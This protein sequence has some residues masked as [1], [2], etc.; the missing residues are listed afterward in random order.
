MERELY[1]SLYE[2]V[3]QC[4]RTRRTKH[5]VFRDAQIVMIYFW[6]VLHDRPTCWAC[7]RTHW[8]SAARHLHLPTPSTMSRRLRRVEVQTLIDTVEQALR[9][10]Q[11]TDEQLM[12]IDAKPLPVGSAT[13]DPDAAAGFAGAGK[14]KGY[15]LHMICD[16]Q[17]IPITWSVV[18]MNH[19]EAKIAPSLVAQL[20]ER[21]PECV[22]LL[23][24]DASYDINT[25]YDQAGSLGWQLYAPRRRGSGFGHYRH[26][27]WR[28]HAQR[29]MPDSWRRSMETPRK[30]IERSFAHLTGGTLGLKP[31]P[32]WVRNLRR[33]VQWVQAKIIIYLTSRYQKTLTNLA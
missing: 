13:K 12:I 23:L 20:P 10:R 6:A 21:S 31:L 33:V 1:R 3:Y 19:N 2:V 7:C 32:S 8:P 26:S 22:G 4:A 16:S 30:I 29:D 15:K 11:S 17:R 14:G 5:V 25:L 18:A 24:G 9:R 27:P 28:L